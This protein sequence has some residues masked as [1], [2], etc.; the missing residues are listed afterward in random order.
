[1][2]VSRGGVDPIVRFGVRGRSYEMKGAAEASEYLTPGTRVSVVYRTDDPT[3]AHIRGF[4]QM[5]PALMLAGAG[6][7]LVAGG[8]LTGWYVLDSARK[9][10]TDA[11]RVIAGS[12]RQPRP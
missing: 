3:Q 10:P 4:R 6:V 7:V 9:R 8:L 12:G 5:I 11:D 2:P 1:M